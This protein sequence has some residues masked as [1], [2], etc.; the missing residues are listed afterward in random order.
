MSDTKETLMFHMV[1]MFPRA[2]RP[3]SKA[4]AAAGGMQALHSPPACRST[5]PPWRALGLRPAVPRGSK[6]EEHLQVLLL[7]RGGAGRVRDTASPQWAL[8]FVRTGPSERRWSM[9]RS[10][11][12]PWQE[13]NPQCFHCESRTR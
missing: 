11:L 9:R 2:V 6:P 5:A 10:D 1:T 3:E 12:R 13:A 4:S 7:S 8:G